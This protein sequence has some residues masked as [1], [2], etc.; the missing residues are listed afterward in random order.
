MFGHTCGSILRLLHFLDPESGSR[1][2]N[3]HSEVILYCPFTSSLL[4]NGPFL[5]SHLLLTRKTT[6][7]FSSHF[8][9]NLHLLM[10]LNLHLHMAL[11]LLLARI[12][13]MS[14]Y[15]SHDLSVSVLLKN[16]S[17]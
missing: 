12:Q 16:S 15:C 6:G 11:N 5:L 14:V 8:Q 2:D 3:F 10:V 13:F 9:L 1:K 4:W 17:Y 7:P